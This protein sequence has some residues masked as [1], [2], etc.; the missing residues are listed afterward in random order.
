MSATHTTRRIGSSVITIASVVGVVIVALM[1]VPALLGF[2]RYVITGGSMSGTFERGSLVFA[3]EV[4]VTDLKP[5]DVITYLPPAD[6]GVSELVTHRIL[7]VAKDASVPSGLVFHTKGDA[8]DSAD[9]WTFT[10][11]AAT[12]ARVEGWVP[13]LGW[14]FIALS[15]PIVRMAAIG[16]PA[17]LIALMYLRDFLRALRPTGASNATAP[18]GSAVVTTAT[19]AIS[20]STSAI[21][22]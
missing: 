11:P 5:G 3:R 1:L 8:N 7:S 17:A 19:A 18:T 15:I 13:T 14:V 16:I 6:S 12:Q 4:P 21:A 10:L 9:P 2:D 22:L 20:T